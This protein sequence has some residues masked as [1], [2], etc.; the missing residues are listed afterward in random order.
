MTEITPSG[1]NIASRHP[2]ATHHTRGILKL[3][4]S[5]MSNVNHCPRCL[6]EDIEF[7]RAVDDVAV[8]RALKIWLVLIPLT[9]IAW[10][11]F[12]RSDMSLVGA[13]LIALPSIWIT[14]PI[15][16]ALLFFAAMVIAWLSTLK[17][18][19]VL[20]TCNRCHHTW[21]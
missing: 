7:V 10:W 13:F 14:G 19:G 18:Q 9:V 21:K 12:L 11:I 4:V 2:I 5:E 6:S 1:A 15:V 20:N 3:E 17:V 16:G 8:R